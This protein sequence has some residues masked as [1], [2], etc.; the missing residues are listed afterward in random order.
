MSDFNPISYTSKTY[1]SILQDI[2]ND[3]ELVDKPNWWKRS[4]A[5]IGDVIS[6]WNNAVA[7]N[8]LLDT[9]YTRRNVLLLLELIDYTMSPQ[10]TSS[11][12]LIFYLD[13]GVGFPKALAVTDL[14]AITSGT[15]DIS[16]KRF[17]ARAAV[18]VASVTEVFAP[19]AV[20]TGTDIITV[21]RDFMTGEKVRFTTVTTLPAPLALATD[22]YIIRVSATEIQVAETLADAIAGTEIN[23]TT[24]G[25]GDH[26]AT[27]YCTQVTCYQQQSKDATTIGTSDG[28]TEWQEFDLPDVDIIDDTLI[29]TI[30]AVQWT[31]VD[32]WIDSG[33]T[34]K[35]FRLFYNDDNTSR[36][37]FGNGVYGEIPGAFDISAEYAV[38]GNSESNITVQ[39]KINIYA[40]TDS[41]V[42]GVTNT[43]TLTGGDDPQSINEAK[44]L[45]P[46]LLKARDRFITTDD[47]EALCIA[48][49]GISQSTV[50]A[51]A[52][53]ILSARVLCIAD[54]GGNP[55]AG[56]KTALQAYL[57]DRT[58][59]ESIDVRVEDA[60]ITSTNVTSAA[61][62]LTG[63]VWA[64]VLPWFRLGWKL[65]LSEAGKEIQ[66]DYT[67]NGV[68][69]ARTL[70]NTIFT[71]AYTTADNTQIQDFL[72][73]LIPREIGEDDIQESDA[74]AFI[75]AHTM[76]VDYMTI[77]APA[78]PIAIL[79][80]EILTYGVLTLT[81]I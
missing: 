9:A 38:G 20:N 7:N 51:N 21:A 16:S 17:E 35:H 60:T 2:N 32:S 41:D 71:E 78:F 57:I 10:T 46:L 37:Q 44:I 45:G 54:G 55:A 33:A 27:L 14:V 67:A 56:V 59:L 5:G 28:I 12:I 47:G 6:M 77:A 30:N 80:D 1:E 26:T 4:I 61:K 65:F 49:G 13:S 75:A 43:D 66:D 15:T 74:F 72:D 29:I 81:E 70:I 3:S 69:S 22:Y 19:A 31:Q 79:E 11:G 53:G 52:F 36:I 58:V 42:T 63:Y 48:Y 40:G 39:D 24:Q 34:D 8:L 50:I 68:N 23:I 64:D 25:V 18:N 62:V 73:N 76:G